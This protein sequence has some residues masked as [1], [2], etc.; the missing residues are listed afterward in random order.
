M[1][2]LQEAA[3]TARQAI[4]SSRG[5]GA[6]VIDGEGQLKVAFMFGVGSENVPCAVLVDTRSTTG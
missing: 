6:I 5:L 1:D 3:D 4:A 2:F